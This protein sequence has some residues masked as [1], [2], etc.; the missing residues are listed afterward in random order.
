M[1]DVVPAKMCSLST[2]VRFSVI[3]I[4]AL[5]CFADHRL[6]CVIWFRQLIGRAQEWMQHCDTKR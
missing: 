4:L 2:A 3:G 6:G 1:S 5:L